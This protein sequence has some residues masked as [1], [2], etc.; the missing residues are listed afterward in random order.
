MQDRIFLLLQLRRNKP[1]V[2]RQRLF[3]DISPFLL[4]L[5]GSSL[6]N[7]NIITEY[8]VVSDSQILDS[9]TFLFLRLQIRDEVSSVSLDFPGLIKFLVISVPEHS[10][11]GHLHG[12][13]LHKGILQL[14]IQILQRICI[15]ILPEYFVIH[16]LQYGRNLRQGLR[17][18]LTVHCIGR[19]HRAAG[20]QSLQII[21]IRQRFT[22]LLSLHEMTHQP[23]HPVQTRFN[24][25]LIHQRLFNPFPQLPGTHR[26]LAAVKKRPQRNGFPRIVQRCHQFQILSGRIIHI[27]NF[28]FLLNPDTLQMGKDMFLCF[29]KIIQKSAVCLQIIILH[30]SVG[31]GKV[32]VPDRILITVGNH[33]LLFSHDMN[34]L[35]TEIL[36][37]NYFPDIG[38]HQQLNQR[39]VFMGNIIDKVLTG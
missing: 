31:Q 15:Q 24:R 6:G 36:R 9:G 29:L 25:R 10:A 23:L 19:I 8:L 27:Q 1:F 18:S 13:I 37:K 22:Q 30:Q 14:L 11:V 28:I 26:T 20:N 3:S 7:F 17:Q 21:D 12:R 5:P 35:F 39:V 33:D 34:Q 32:L 2:I 38:A 16:R 4:H